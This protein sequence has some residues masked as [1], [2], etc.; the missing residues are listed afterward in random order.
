MTALSFS[1]AVGFGLALAGAAGWCFWTAVWYQRPAWSAP[2]LT[3]A[4][5]WVGQVLAW[6]LLLVLVGGVLG[7][8]A[9]AAWR[10]VNGAG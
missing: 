1:L 4:C 9:A 8:V 3:L 2:P 7:V 5:W 10:L 6:G